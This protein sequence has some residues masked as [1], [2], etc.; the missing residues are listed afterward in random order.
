[1]LRVQ[2]LDLSR[3]ELMVRH[4]KGGKDRVSVVPDQMIR[5][6]TEHLASLNA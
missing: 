6:L 4:A 2:E 5:P 3:H 1:M